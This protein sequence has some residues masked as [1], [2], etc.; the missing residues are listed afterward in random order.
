MFL[1]PRNL[2][3]VT[4]ALRRTVVAAAQRSLSGTSSTRAKMSLDWADP[5]EL[6]TLL[7]DEEKMIMETAR[8]YAQSKLMPRILLA[9]RHER[10]DR[11]IMTELG[12]MGLLGGAW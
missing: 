6:H 3:S 1:Q 11:A 2:M 10:F 5:L 9:N 4:A 7:S 8:G 12:E